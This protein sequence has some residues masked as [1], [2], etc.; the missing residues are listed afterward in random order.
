MSYM[1]TFIVRHLF[2]VLLL[3][4]LNELDLVLSPPNKV[5]TQNRMHCCSKIL[6]EIWACLKRRNADISE[7]NI[8]ESRQI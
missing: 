7:K 6:F 4:K 2:K 1:I 5:Q 8:E 3:E